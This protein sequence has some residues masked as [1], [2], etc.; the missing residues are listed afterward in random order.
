MSLLRSVSLSLDLNIMPWACCVIRSF[1]T[2]AQQDLSDY[3]V[4]TKLGVISLLDNHITAVLP[5][6]QPSILRPTPEQLGSGT[7]MID[8]GNLCI[9]RITDKEK[10]DTARGYG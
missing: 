4:L 1:P 7:S 5:I 6:F 10:A 3:R 8:R 2:I 9:L